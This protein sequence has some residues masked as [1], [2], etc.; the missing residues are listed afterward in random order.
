MNK[1]G[2]TLVEVAI[3]LIIIGIIL[4]MVFKGRQVIDSAKVKSL[5]ANYNKIQTA[6]DT[7]YDRYGFY[8][9]DGCTTATPASVSDCNGEKDGLIGANSKSKEL[10]AFWYLLINVTGLLTQADRK[11][12]SGS[13]WDIEYNFHHDRTGDWLIAEIPRKYI[14]AFDQKR[15]DGDNHKGR[16][17]AH[18]VPDYH[19]DTDCWKF[20]DST[21]A[22]LYLLP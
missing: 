15:E 20:T 8:P 13:E 3:V 7:F 10:D 5:E 4:G 11:T 21:Q 2:F 14:C 6:I 1:K 16:I 19:P 22:R 9:G 12:I 18:G 17:Q